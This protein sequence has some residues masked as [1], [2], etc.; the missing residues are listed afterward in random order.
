MRVK[1][2]TVRNLL[3][4]SSAKQ[5]P[6]R[7]MTFAFAFVVLLF[8]FREQIQGGRDGEKEIDQCPLAEL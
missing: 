8:H 6:K 5:T 2:K 4:I 3:V 7:Q 1:E